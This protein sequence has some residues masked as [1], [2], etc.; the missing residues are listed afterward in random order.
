M[1]GW[2]TRKRLF[3]L[4]GWLG[5]HLGFLLFLICISGTI[6]VFT[7]E[8]DWL[9]DPARRVGP[10]DGRAPASAGE[11][12]ALVSEE[13]PRAALA[14]IIRS[15]SA[16]HA[17][18]AMIRYPNGV[19]RILFIDQY[20]RKITGERTFLDAKSFT[21]IFHKQFYLVPTTIGFHGTW[22]V[23]L[24]SIVLLGSVITGLM[25]F[26]HPF[27]AMF[28]IRWRKRGRLKWSDIHRCLGVWGLV[29][30]LV[31]S[32]TGLWYLGER[33]GEDAGLIEHEPPAAKIA[34]E[35]LSEYGWKLQWR[36]LDDLMV[37]AQR[38][39]PELE[40]TRITLPMRPGD[41]LRIYGNAE[42]LAVRD[43]ANSV[44]LNPVSGEIVSIERAIESSPT[45]RL[46]HSIDPIHFGTFGGVLTRIIWFVSGLAISVG[47][48]AGA[49]LYVLRVMRKTKS[50]T[51][52]KNK[53]WAVSGVAT[54]LVIGAS[55]FSG[56]AFILAGQLHFGADHSELKHVGDFRFGDVEARVFRTT[57]SEDEPSRIFVRF[58]NGFQPG[59][60]AVSVSDTAYGEDA[61]IPVQAIGNGLSG[62]TDLP[63]EAFHK[64]MR[65]RLLFGDPK[66]NEASVLSEPIQSGTGVATL[67]ISRRPEIP[68]SV[69]AYIGILLAVML[70]PGLLWI[71]ISRF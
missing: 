35:E 63:E 69:V 41:L 44:S 67:P 31:V 54:S 61:V 70:V 21:R 37:I 10:G 45:T 16:S 60:K 64:T 66:G 15:P 18:G 23:G 29:V 20:Q 56:T 46:A 65:M 28:L 36:P 38:A 59:V 17:D 22:I 3:K 58:P 30:A 32:L 11:I 7:P 5:L 47:I 25:A 4:H 42:A 39:Y 49:Y 53:G 48:L 1:S 12:A 9:L 26:K 40:P 24:F 33:A 50:D 2:F 14:Y 68:S 19:A 55:A 8:I 71:R 13:R 52:T 57:V 27:G 34:D 62:T 6:A 51:A 43:Q